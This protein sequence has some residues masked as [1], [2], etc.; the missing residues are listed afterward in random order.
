MNEPGAAGEWN[1]TDCGAIVGEADEVCPNCG[2]SLTEELDSPPARLGYGMARV[3]RRYVGEEI[4]VNWR[5]VDKF[6]RAK[7]VA[8]SPELVTIDTPNGLIHYSMRYVMFCQEGAYEIGGLM[9]KREVPIL[10]QVHQ[11]V[12]YQGWVGISVPLPFG[13]DS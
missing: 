5:A 12:I 6:E 4:G 1:C 11:V 10:M 9:S 8:A 2:E 7:L 3:L 13:S